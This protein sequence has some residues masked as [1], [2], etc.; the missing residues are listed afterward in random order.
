MEGRIT[1]RVVC[2]ELDKYAF[3]WAGVA[4]DTAATGVLVESTNLK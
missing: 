1:W 4:G 3:C 2:S